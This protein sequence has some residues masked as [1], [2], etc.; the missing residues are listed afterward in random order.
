MMFTSSLNPKHYQTF[1]NVFMGMCGVAAFAG[2]ALLVS[3]LFGYDKGV[4]GA[5]VMFA[6]SVGIVSSGIMEK[7]SRKTRDTG[8][9]AAVLIANFVLTAVGVWLLTGLIPR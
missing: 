5:V 9:P 3:A 4:D 1:H 7:T 6:G 2:T 8:V